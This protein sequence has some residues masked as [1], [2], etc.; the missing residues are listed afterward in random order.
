MEKHYSVFKTVERSSSQHK[1]RILRGIF[2]Y[3]CVDYEKGIPDWAKWPLEAYCKNT[4]RES[5]DHYDLTS[6]VQVWRREEAYQDKLSRCHMFKTRWFIHQCTEDGILV[7]SKLE[8]KQAVEWA[9]E[10]ANQGRIAEL[11]QGKD[12]AKV[13]AE[14]LAQL[15]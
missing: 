9:R 10:R 8:L 12:G 13:K 6:L 5:R 4:I 1:D 7:P 15:G 3:Y 11:K 2:F 14:Y